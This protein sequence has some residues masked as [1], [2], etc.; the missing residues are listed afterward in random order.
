MYMYLHTHTHIHIYIHTCTCTHK[1]IRL[2]ALLSVLQGVSAS[3]VVV[4]FIRVLS[5][6]KKFGKF[7]LTYFS[8]FT[9]IKHG[10]VVA[11]LLWVAFTLA[12]VGLTMLCQTYPDYL[13]MSGAHAHTY[14]HTLTHIHAHA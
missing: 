1:H 5:V 6:F 11:L 8:M 9:A 4:R 14:T 12:R 7:V 2:L 10:F 13:L 3:L